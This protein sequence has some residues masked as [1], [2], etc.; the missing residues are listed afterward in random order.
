MRFVLAGLALGI[1]LIGCS[2]NTP[3]KLAIGSYPNVVYDNKPFQLTP[4]V[5]N[6]GGNPIAGVSVTYQSSP[7]GIADVSS[8]G[9]VRCTTSGDAT[10]LANGG[11]QSALATIKCR[12]IAKIELPKLQL[13]I[14]GR[15]EGEFHPVIYNE[16]GE[17]ISDAQV[18]GKSDNQT[19]VSFEGNRI[20][21]KGVGKTSVTYTAGAITTSMD[22]AVA[23]QIQELSGPLALAD[24]ETKTVTLQKGNYA[25]EIMV[26][27]QGGGGGVGVNVTSTGAS[28]SQGERDQHKFQ[29]SV[30]DS[31]ALTIAN[32]ST[33]GLGASMVGF[34][35]VYELPPK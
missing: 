10:I 9:E 3:V 12:L 16:K 35:N 4:T 31:A 15:N 32:P 22:V 29:C 21:P 11:G 8:N 33:F 18:I 19:I 7:L 6:K 25:I 2:D 1:V 20:V 17:V 34:M 13:F 23:R 26:T 30:S 24:R 14:I 27:P 5:Q 28:C